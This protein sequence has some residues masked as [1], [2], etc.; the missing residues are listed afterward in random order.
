MRNFIVTT[1]ESRGAR[2]YAKVH[3]TVKNVPKKLGEVEWDRRAFRGGASEVTHFLVREGHIPRE[4]ARE[5]EYYPGE[6]NGKFKLHW[7]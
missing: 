5:G 4:W 3:E 7:L 1:E 2:V 6:G